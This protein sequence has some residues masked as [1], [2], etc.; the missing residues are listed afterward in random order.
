MREGPANMAVGRAGEPTRA[1]AERESGGAQ[2]KR[3]CDLVV[4]VDMKGTGVGDRTKG[5]GGIHEVVAAKDP[6]KL[7]TPLSRLAIVP[8]LV[9]MLRECQGRAGRGRTGG[10]LM[11][12]FPGGGT[13]SGHFCALDPVQSY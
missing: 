13:Y 5:E 12:S 4:D 9:L 1:G 7:Q 6:G 3:G 11:F 2:L 8:G 10:A